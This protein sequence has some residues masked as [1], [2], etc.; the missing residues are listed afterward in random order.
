MLKL[1]LV[2]AMSLVVGALIA[3]YGVQGRADAAA[4]SSCPRKAFTQFRTATLGQ[5]ASVP[6]P[7]GC[8]DTLLL[9][10]YLQVYAL[11]E[12]SATQDTYLTTLQGRLDNVCRQIPQIRC[13]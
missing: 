2:A 5:G 3:T 12:H 8:T 7:Q 4:V 10:L 13:G 1:M 9:A 6:V 11:R